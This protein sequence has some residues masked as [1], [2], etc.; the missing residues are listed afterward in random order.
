MLTACISVCMIILPVALMK[1]CQVCV[2]MGKKGKIALCLCKTTNK[3]N[4]SANLHSNTFS[5]TP[6]STQRTSIRLHKINCVCSINELAAQTKRGTRS[7][8]LKGQCLQQ[9]LDDNCNPSYIV[10]IPSL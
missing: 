8:N 10:S 6:P 1:G 7:G 3:S 2:S 5:P 4:H 9:R